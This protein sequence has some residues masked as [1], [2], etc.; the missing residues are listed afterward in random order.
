MELI[1][2][3]I[4]AD[5]DAFAAMVAASRLHPEARMFFPGSRE[6]SLR[7]M[8]ESGLV[9]LSE[10]R[11]KEVDPAALTRVILCDVRQKERIGVVAEW[12]EKYPEIEVWAYDHHPDTESDVEVRGGIVDPGVGSTSTILVEELRR[13]GLTCNAPEA[14]LLLLGIYE[15]TGSLTYATTSPRDFEA[16]V[17][18]LSQGGDLA[19]VRRFVS[20]PLDPERLEI[21]HRMTQRLEVHRIHGHRIGIVEVDLKTYVEELAPLVS[22]CLEVFE[23]PAL[24]ALFG[25]G[26]EGDR[27]TLIARG[28]LESFDLGDFLA[29]FGG[30]GHATAASARIKGATTLETRERLLQE[31]SKALPPAALARDLMISSYVEI[32]GGTSVEE[33]KALLNTRRVNAAPVVGSEGRVIGIVSRQ[34]LDAALQ[35]GLGARPVSTVMTREMEWIDPEAPAEAVGE[36]MLARHPRFVLVGDPS[37]GKPLGLITRMQVL[38]HLHGRLSDFERR[39][40]RRTEQLREKKE[41]VADLLEERLPELLLRY[42]GRIAAVSQRHGF[43]V[44]LVGGFVRDLLL[45]RE[46]RDLDLVVE[47]DGLGFAALLAEEL[48]G[49]VRT[50]PVFL[51]AV[52]VDPEGFHIDI[53]TARSEFYRA[54][55]AL[56]EV[57]TSALR[58]DLYRRDFTINTLAIRLGPGTTPELIDYFGGR[59]DLKEKTLRVLHSLSFIDDPTRVL[60]AV[61]LELRLGFHISSETLRLVEVA[62]DEG[63]FDH[64]SGSRLR[65]ELVMLLDD[66]ALALRGIERL[67]EL[68]LL[69]VLHP[70]IS[71]G[72]DSR[73]RLRGA[74]AAWDWY[75]LEGLTDPPV[76][77]WRL[78]LMA[79]SGDLGEPELER[80]ADRLMLAGEDRRLLVSF[81]G[82][83]ERARKA[84]E[85]PDLL[86]HQALEALEPLQG[87]ELLLLMA[88]EN[89]AVRTWVRRH[90]S[91]LRPFE[92]KIRGADLVAAGVPPGPRIG[93]ALKATKRARLDGRIEAGEELRHALEEI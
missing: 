87:E 88:D 24:F 2:T 29:V 66:P 81:P 21:L 8:L 52:V 37:S 30:G 49:R 7:R 23:L 12:L 62:L 28:D 25:E 42:I 79:L 93:E 74:R 4:G 35:H 64:L 13:R 26:T 50:H 90:L 83:L 39:F 58:Q 61:R 48:G 33:A 15:D 46:N 56:P 6:E 53:A 18:L 9:V 70:G 27:V 36:R 5:F 17:W 54:P 10:L 69:R 20:R 60:R 73:E 92:L 63:I 41:K 19:T 1:S 14:D 67:A 47:G 75:H 51:T 31:L 32:P 84:L 22:R 71:W 45:D 72:D 78:H 44:Y 77:V 40:D 57:Q 68:D 89:E 34:I 82:R 85:A 3:H 38:R 16:A 65:D 59:H 43:P 76:R 91:E 11:H 86:P 80:L 55:A